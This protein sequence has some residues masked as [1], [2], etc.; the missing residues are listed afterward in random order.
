M[1][2]VCQPADVTLPPLPQRG[3][4][5]RAQIVLAACGCAGLS[6]F[7][8][9]V[10][11]VQHRVYPQCWLYNMTGIYCAG[12]GATRAMHA[13]L[14]GRILDALHDNVLF[15]SALP[16]LLFVVGSYALSAWQAKAWPQKDLPASRL[17][18][19]AIGTVAVMLAFMAL[20]NIPGWPFSLLRPLP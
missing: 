13:L 7:L 19:W 17:A 3:L 2:P 20:R 4:P 5:V 15:V 9:A 12:C 11:P 14:H 16:L 8:Y 10:D 1:P 6:A 18:R